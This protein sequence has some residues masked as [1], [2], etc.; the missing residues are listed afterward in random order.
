MK[1]FW[2]IF[3][4]PSLLIMPA[5]ALAQASGSNTTQTCDS[6]NIIITMDA[7]EN[8]QYNLP[9]LT[10][11]S[12]SPFGVNVKIPARFAQNS[13]SYFVSVIDTKM[14][15]PRSEITNSAD[16]RTLGSSPERTEVINGTTYNVYYWEFSNFLA[17]SSAANL[18]QSFAI[19]LKHAENVNVGPISANTPGDHVT[20]TVNLAPL[21][22]GATY[23]YRL[24][25]GSH[26]T[27]IPRDP[28]NPV[29]IKNMV[30]YN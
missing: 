19:E 22:D 4:L 29:D 14:A 17:N 11:G 2:F 7:P 16:N 1:Q 28:R 18:P 27:N 13:W 3:L 15:G 5:T 6:Q 24:D 30:G 10:I 26:T 12:G 21:P 25:Q 23:G 8:H 9:D 20:G